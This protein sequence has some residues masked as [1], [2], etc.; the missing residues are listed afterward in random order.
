ML[1][2]HFRGGIVECSPRSGGGMP[3]TPRNGADRT[4]Y[5]PRGHHSPSSFHMNPSPW[6]PLSPPR[7]RGPPLAVELPH[8]PF[9]V[10]PRLPP[11]PRRHLVDMDDERLTRLRA[12]HFERPLERVARALRAIRRIDRIPL[13]PCIAGLED[14]RFPR[15]D[16]R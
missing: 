6:A 13:P 2:P 3:T 15:V 9:P 5:S 1:P 7:P 12:V 8:E 11:R 16:G 10:G 14:H 4:P